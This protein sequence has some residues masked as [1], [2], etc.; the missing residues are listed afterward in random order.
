MVQRSVQ[1]SFLFED[2][3]KTALQSVLYENHLKLINKNRMAEFAGYLMPLWFSSIAA[4]HDA[5]RNSAGLFDCTH[6]GILGFKGQNAEEFLNI[7]TTNDVTRLKNHKAQYSYILDAAG[8]VLDDIIVYKRDD[9]KFM[10]VVNA[11]NEPKI[12]AYL[13]ALQKNEAIIDIDDNERK[14]KEFPIITDMRDTT[15]GSA[16]CRVD[17]ALQGPASMEILCSLINDQAIQKQIKELKSFNLLETEI[18]GINCIISRTG[19]TGAQVSYE[20]F[21]HP[22]KASE[23]WELLLD[24]GQSNNLLPCGLGARDSLRI[25][26]GLPL[27]GHELDGE[28]NISP[29]EAGYGWAVKLE[30][31]FFIGKA[32]MQKIAKGWDMEVARIEIPGEKGIRPVRTHDA[33]LDEN[34]I[35]IGWV[36]SCAKADEKQIALVYISKETIEVNKE[37]GIYYLARSKGQ[38]EKGKK[39]H[40]QINEKLEAEISAIIVNRFAKF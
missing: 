2:E 25:E 4:E 23:L 20:L 33:V 37:L 32:A 39:E 6:M 11:A 38:I 19:Y 27:Y 31:D 12:K 22:G 35:C 28:F 29:F 36:L 18:Q 8:N 14:I 16:D 1:G 13:N 10:V 17:I 40:V 7:I 34:G 21:V 26:A 15:S 9:D 30:K 3:E 24:K 5:V